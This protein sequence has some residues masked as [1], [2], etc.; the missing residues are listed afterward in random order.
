MTLDLHNSRSHRRFLA[1]GGEL[2]GLTRA[3]DWASSS[4]GAPAQWPQ[5]LRTAV[6]L[7]LT[8]RHP[9]FIWWGPDLIQFY[10]DAYR[11]TMGPERHPSA[12]GDKGRD[13]WAE[14]WPVIG[15][16]I[17][18]VMRGEGATW[19]EDQLVP[20]TRFGSLQ[21]VWWTYGYSPIDAED[22]VGGVLVV[23]K[24]V[25]QE[26]L[27]RD[28]LAAANHQLNADVESLREMFSQAP[29]FMAMMTG[30]DHVFRFANDA[31]LKLVGRSDVVG[32]SAREMLPD[33]EGQGFF[34]ILDKVYRTGRAHVGSGELIRFQPEPG[35]PVE[36]YYLDFVYQ[37][38]RNR[39]GDVFGI[40]VEGYDV[41][42]RVESE[43]HRKL[44]VDE[45]NHRVKNTLATVQALAMMA[46]KSAATVEEFR[47]SLYERIASMARTQDLLI[48]GQAQPVFVNDVIFVELDPYG[49]GDQATLTCGE[50]TI[51]AQGAVSLGLLIHELATNAAK[52]GALSGLGGQ[53]NVE[54]QADGHNG[55]LI[56]T[57]TFGR[58]APPPVHVGFGTRLV[59]RLARDLGGAATIDLSANGLTAT[60]TFRLDGRAL[61]KLH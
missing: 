52:Y 51:G 3:Y 54:C 39:N 49:A 35:G 40:F 14:I 4:L 2:G 16:Q 58:P 19:H 20:V 15:P 61:S 18:F 26:H 17:D 31:Y 22:G 38:I 48:D 12:L 45:M 13:C 21:D 30:S 43:R 44:V 47:A 24:D 9:M 36:Q 53:L 42:E 23:C 32:K 1:G 46:G 33:V 60:V 56:W 55:K 29:G 10:N 28:A 6:R 27:A 50:I 7:M 25:T 57:E 59:Q 11:E 8:S 34:E 37:P 5:S 41:T